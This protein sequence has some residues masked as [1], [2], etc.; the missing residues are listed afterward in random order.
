MKCF[1]RYT[2]LACFLPAAFGARSGRSVVVQSYEMRFRDTF[3]VVARPRSDGEKLPIRGPPT[4]S[5]NSAINSECV[6]RLSH[7]NQIKSKGNWEDFTTKDENNAQKKGIHDSMVTAPE[8][9]S[10]SAWLSV[11]ARVLV[12]FVWTRG[13]GF[14]YA[15]HFTSVSRCVNAGLMMENVS[16]KPWCY[17]AEVVCTSRTAKCC[18]PSRKYEVP[19][20]Q[21]HLTIS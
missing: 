1:K 12:M 18:T 2:R 3:S 19:E 13:R 7:E 6:S 9:F 14:L 20:K 17:A 15:Q 11:C 10:N 4:I 21:Q 16:V 5:T 8:N